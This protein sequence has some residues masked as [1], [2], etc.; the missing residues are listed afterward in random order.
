MQRTPAGQEN[1]LVDDPSF[2]LVWDLRSPA[3][4]TG[5]RAHGRQ[6]PRVWRSARTGARSTRPSRSRRTTWRPAGRCGRP[7]PS[8]GWCS[9]SARTASCSP[10]RSTRPDSGP[11]RLTDARTGETCGSC[12]ATR[13]SPGHAL[14]ATTA[15]G[16]P[17]SPTTASSS[18]GTCRTGKPLVTADT[19]EVGFSVDF[20]PDGRR[21]YT[22]GDDADVADLGPVRR[23]AVPAPDVRAARRSRTSSMSTASP[24]G[25]RLAYLSAGLTRELGPSSSTPSRERGRTRASAVS[26]GRH[27]RRGGPGIP[28]AGTT[29]SIGDPSGFVTVLD[30]QTGKQTATPPGASSDA[31]IYSIGYVDKGERLIVGDSKGRVSF[32][33]ADTLL[34]ERSVRGRRRTAVPSAP[35]TAAPRWCST[36]RRMAPRQTWRVIDTT[37]G[38]VLNEGPLDLRA[39]SAAFSP[40]GEHVAV[41]GNSGEVVA[42]DVSSERV[43]ARTGH[44]ACRGGLLGPL[45]PGRLSDR[46]RRGRR[47]R[48]PLGRRVAR[49]A[50]DGRRPR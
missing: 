46:L 42:I 43:T 40:D 4:R 18:C 39:Y 27:R 17:P 49:P 37:S 16:W 23:P 3:R 31:D 22:G 7:S 45:V 12:A 5:N 11:I 15:A 26:S 1:S 28:M 20:S 2:V 10:P 25:R 36:T 38:E 21:V 24:D 34:S 6:V 29:R 50:G 9:T 44:R 30:A 32:V 14:L 33:D 41:T 48:E 19:F 13:T 47:Q 8:R 35:R